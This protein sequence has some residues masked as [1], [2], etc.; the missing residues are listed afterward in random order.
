LENTNNKIKI[1]YELSRKA[2]HISYS[3]TGFIYMLYGRELITILLS[4]AV[5]FMVAFDVGRAYSENIQKFYH[6]IFR[7]ILR[8]HEV[9]NRK[10][11]FTGG[12]Y[13]VISTFFI[14][15]VFPMPVAVASI[16]IATFAD[17][18]AAIVGRLIGRIKIYNK[19]LEGSIAF[20]I[21]GLIIILLTP[22][23]SVDSFE[24]QIAV[25]SLIICSVIEVLPVKIDDNLTL[26]LSFS[27][28]YFVLLRIFNLY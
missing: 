16:F 14:V 24:Y 26:P 15:L 25:F 1:G 21:T 3:L 27:V 17:S 20:F 12:T 18:A 6:F 10:S 22:K 5:V 8:E 19:T 13:L 28:I 23:V 4:I 9:D 2:I 7:K 11:L